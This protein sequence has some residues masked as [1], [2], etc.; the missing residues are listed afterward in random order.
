MADRLNDPTT[1]ADIV[2]YG[3]ENPESSTNAVGELLE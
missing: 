3:I 1:L 2:N